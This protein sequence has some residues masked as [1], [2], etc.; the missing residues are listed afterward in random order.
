[1]VVGSSDVDSVRGCNFVVKGSGSI[2][3]THGASCVSGHV[4]TEGMEGIG[5]EASNAGGGSRGR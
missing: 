4:G 2:T 1:V 3:K 5:G